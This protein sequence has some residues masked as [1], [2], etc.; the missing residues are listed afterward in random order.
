MWEASAWLTMAVL[1][2]A[3]VA[4][5][6]VGGELFVECCCCVKRSG[7]RLLVLPLVKT[8]TI[9]HRVLLR[10]RAQWCLGGW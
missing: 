2:L 8:A 5:V 4:T 7:D 3:A 6:L 10:R 1:L 9:N